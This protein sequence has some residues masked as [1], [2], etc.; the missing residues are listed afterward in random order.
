MKDARNWKS[1][2]NVCV[3]KK[4]GPAENLLFCFLQYTQGDGHC[5]TGVSLSS[6]LSVIGPDR[7]HGHLILKFPFLLSFLFGIPPSHEFELHFLPLIRYA[8]CVSVSFS[9]SH[10][11]G[12]FLVFVSVLP[13]TFYSFI[14]SISQLKVKQSRY[15]PGQ[16]Q[17]V[18]AD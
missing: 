14:F 3:E 5:R 2:R 13:P 12:L 6:S 10:C 1:N 11:S 18:T 16:A 4:Y 9:H 7:T 17:R 8:F 15:R